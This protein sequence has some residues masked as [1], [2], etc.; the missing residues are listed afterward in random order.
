MLHLFWKTGVNFSNILTSN[1]RGSDCPQAMAWKSLAHSFRVTNTHT[2]TQ[3]RAHTQITYDIDLNYLVILTPNNKYTEEYRRKG[4]QIRR[5]TNILVVVILMPSWKEEFVVTKVIFDTWR[6]E[7]KK[8]V[9]HEVTARTN[10]TFCLTVTIVRP[11]Q[12]R[13][14]L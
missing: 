6:G 3:A 1:K 4:R 11:R 10:S 13:R 7:K 5:R 8:K 14:E 2:H 12:Q 9:C